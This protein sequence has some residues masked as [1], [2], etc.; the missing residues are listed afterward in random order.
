MKIVQSYWSKP[1]METGG[2]RGDDRQRGGWIDIRFHYMSWALSC[3]NFKKFYNEV[4]LVTDSLG[5]EILINRIGL[6]YSH[7]M[8]VLDC[9]EN[10][11]PAVW[12]IS[13]FHAYT[14]QKEPFIHADNDVF[15]WR[16]L[17]E[18]EHKPLVV[19]NFEVNVSFYKQIWKEIVDQFSYIPLCMRE[20]FI[21]R[22]EIHSCNAGVFGGNDLVFIKEFATEAMAFLAKNKLAMKNMRMPGWT[23]LI[24]EQY[25]FSCLARAKQKQ[26][27][28]L[29][30]F[31]DNRNVEMADF[32]KVARGKFYVHTISNTKQ[33]EMTCNSLSERL[34]L[35]HPEYYYRIEQLAKAHA[36]E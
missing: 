3:L 25:L 33:N 13:K 19:Q 21:A 6:P 7:T 35:E 27:T 14:L 8:T 32:S 24:Y 20:D 31:T 9:Y 15:I 5:K 34:R 2:R 28:A 18:L 30:S 4:E 23:V 16:T 36:L 12:A 10:E 17:T 22:P 29:F 11:D 26:V 1:V